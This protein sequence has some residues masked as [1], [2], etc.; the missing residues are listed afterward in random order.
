MSMGKRRY[1]QEALFI[2]TEGL[3]RS[4]GHP[5][6]RKLNELLAEAQFDRW[7]ERRCERYYEQVETRGQRSIPPG[8]YFRMLLVGYFEGIDS[9]RG[10]AWRCA[11]SLSLRQF[12]GLGLDEKTPDHS[13][14]TNT[15]QRLP[16]E[17]F[18]E[19]FQFVLRIASEKKLLAGKTVGVDSTTLEANA[20][21]KSIVRRE[22]GEDWNTYVTRLMRED[23][24]IEP[25]EEPTDEDIRRYDKRRKNKRVSNDDWQ[26]PSD[27]ES[28][29]T[30]LKDG[31]THLAYKAEHVVDLGSELVVAAEVYPGDCAD[32]DTLA[33]SLLQAQVNLNEAESDVQIEEAVADK[34]YHAAHTLELC[35]W[36][37]VRTYV[38]EPRRVHRSRWTDKPEEH[39]QAVLANR[40]RTKRAKSKRLQRLRSERCERS[41][42]HVC[43]S[44]GARRSWLRGVE[45][46]SKRYLIAVAAHN[47]GRILRL[48]FGIGKPK[49]LQGLLVLAALVQLLSRLLGFTARRLAHL[50]CPIAQPTAILT[51][52]TPVLQKPIRSTGC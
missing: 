29:I 43:D 38:P 36:M 50:H 35:Q 25:D 23:G 4:P 27:P 11:D 15:R 20:A 3:A 17:V 6:Y 37:G 26:S 5:F 40:R 2:T 12:L 39:H 44:G 19:V 8:V 32:T 45:N 31:R 13:T 41:F 24:T 1:K 34:G 14:L 48:L 21:M 9:Q 7:I 52:L 33:D 49:A 16:A 46:V 28:R 51:P 22:T 18:G 10:I 47:L 30:K 42:A